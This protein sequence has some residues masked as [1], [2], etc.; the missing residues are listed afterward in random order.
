MPFWHLG[1]CWKFGCDEKNYWIA[2]TKAVEKVRVTLNGK[3]KEIQLDGKKIQFPR[4]I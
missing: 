1:N 4:A 2:P 3:L